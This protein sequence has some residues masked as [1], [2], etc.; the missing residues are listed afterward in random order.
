MTDD[1]HKI[2]RRKI[3]NLI[4]ELTKVESIETFT[5]P[6]NSGDTYD[7]GR[8]EC[9]KQY[10][11]LMH[12]ELFL[13]NDASPKT[14]LIGEAPGKND[15]LISG[16]PFTDGKIANE[17]FYTMDISE[18]ASG[19][20]IDM[21]MVKNVPDSHDRSSKTLWKIFTKL[22][23]VPLMWNIFPFYP[24]PKKRTITP[25]EIM[26]AKHFLELFLDIFSEREIY[27][28]SKNASLIL[29]DLKID[30]KC[31]DGGLLKYKTEL[32]KVIKAELKKL[33]WI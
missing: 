26:L 27:A 5:N 4:K 17:Y 7:K 12:G 13:S 28:A 20:M 8:Q 11:Y 32:P 6:Y 24:L 23:Y 31:L 19:D 14:L 16:I 18:S 9:L 15:A 10:L 29:T 3:Q 30:H 25:E 21:L 2:R 22:D 1:L 33:N